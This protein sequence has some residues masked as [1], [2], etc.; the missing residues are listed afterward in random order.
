MLLP[1]RTEFAEIDVEANAHLHAFCPVSCSFRGHAG[2]IPRILRRN[3]WHLSAQLKASTMKALPDE[4][5][6]GLI[7]AEA[8]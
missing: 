4:Q 8:S 7:A 2:R 6:H 3:P 5:N 1:D